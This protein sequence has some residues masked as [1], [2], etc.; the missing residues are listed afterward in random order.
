MDRLIIYVLKAHSHYGL[1]HTGITPLSCKELVMASV[2]RHGWA[3]EIADPKFKAGRD[4][5][6]AAVNQGG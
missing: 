2:K 4:V 1:Q 6:I 5:V 3:L